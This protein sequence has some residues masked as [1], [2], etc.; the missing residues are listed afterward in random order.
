[1]TKW[2]VSSDDQGGGEQVFQCEPICLFTVRVWSPESQVVELSRW[3]EARLG[4]E[5]TAGFNLHQ[6]HMTPELL[7]TWQP[8]T[9]A[10]LHQSTW[11]QNLANTR[12]P[13]Y[14]P[15][16]AG[17]AMQGAQELGQT[18]A[19]GTDAIIMQCLVK[20]WH[21]YALVAAY[22]ECGNIWCMWCIFMKW[23]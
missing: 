5:L 18:P 8:G 3:G 17:P 22:G 20:T 6:A 12:T 4:W 23:V 9:R 13:Q 10:P 21:N 14:D 7:G 11:H 1:M 2:L 16:I 15:D 19:G